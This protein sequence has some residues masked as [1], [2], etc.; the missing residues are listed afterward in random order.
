MNAVELEEVKCAIFNT[1]GVQ[2]DGR[3]DSTSRRQGLLMWF[4]D[5]TSQGG[6]KFSIR[7]RG[8]N[9]HR[10]SVEFGH[11]SKNC[12]DHINERAE[13]EHYQTAIAHLSTIKTLKN[14][15]VE[16]GEQLEDGNID[17]DFTLRVTRVG[18]EDQHDSRNIIATV[19][20]IIVP[21]MAGFAELIGYEEISDNCPEGNLGEIDGRISIVLTKRRE[22]NPRNKLL[23]LSIH[24]RKCGVCEFDPTTVYQEAYADI[25]EV[26]HIEPLSENTEA[27]RYN[28]STDLIPLCP[29]CHRAIHRRIPALSLEELKNNFKV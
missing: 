28:P 21:I 11:Y 9:R 26:H 15:K 13:Q 29:N 17:T 2:V 5:Y 20:E 16:G 12:I 23:C 27:R 14:T 1:I 7:P 6:P 8:L 19:K 18:L 10:V 3:V 4:T 22:R 25:L 24:G